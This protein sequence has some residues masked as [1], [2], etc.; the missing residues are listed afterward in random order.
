[1]VV[2]QVVGACCGHLA[3]GG[4]LLLGVGLVVVVVI[5]PTTNGDRLCIWHVLRRWLLSVSFR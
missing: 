1:M 5:V 2:V 3:G 4:D